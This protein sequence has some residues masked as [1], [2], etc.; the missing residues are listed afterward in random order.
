MVAAQAHCAIRLQ[1]TNQC[2]HLCRLAATVNVV[3]KEDQLGPGWH[4][5]QK[6]QKLLQTAMHVGNHAG[7]A[8][9]PKAFSN[10]SSSSSDRLL[11][12]SVWVTATVAVCSISSLSPY[13][14]GRLLPALHL[15]ASM[16]T[17]AA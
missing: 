7:I 14:L 15:Y 13:R 3:A 11:T 6:A 8:H 10:T 16:A 5:V 1:R 17:R 4:L 2:H 9:L 12:S